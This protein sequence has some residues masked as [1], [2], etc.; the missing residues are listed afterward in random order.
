VVRDDVGA[1]GVEALRFEGV[2]VAGGGEVD[3]G[4]GITRG[5]LDRV[6]AAANLSR[7]LST[8]LNELDLRPV[9]VEPRPLDVVDGD[10]TVVGQVRRTSRLNT[11]SVDRI[12]QS[13]GQRHVAAWN[14]GHLLTTGGQ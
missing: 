1:A 11:R 10:A 4:A 3:L 6:N 9:L 2:R 8:T 13:N 14:V 5:Q 7:G 12:L